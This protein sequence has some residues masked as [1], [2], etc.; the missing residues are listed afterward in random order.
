MPSFPAAA[1]ARVNSVETLKPRPVLEW[2]ARNG[3]GVA[4]FLMSAAAIVVESATVKL[5]RIEYVASFQ[6][7]VVTFAM[8]GMGLGSGAL[9]ARKNAR[10]SREP[11][12]AAS[13]A[14]VA[15][16]AFVLGQLARPSGTIL[17]FV[18]LNVL[19][20]GVFVA[21]GAALT[22]LFLHAE[23][24]RVAYAENLGGSGAGAA[25]LPVLLAHAGLE[26]ALVVVALALALVAS[27]LALP[28]RRVLAAT[29]GAVA[30]AVAIAFPTLAE[31]R[32]LREHTRASQRSSFEVTRY[33]GFSRIDVRRD[34]APIEWALGT[35]YSGPPTLGRLFTIDGV[36]AGLARYSSY[37]TGD[38][39]GSLAWDITALP[40]HA[41]A[42]SPRVLVIG[43]GGGKDVVEAVRNARA[44]SVVAVEINP[45]VID[46]MRERFPDAYRRAYDDPRVE[47]RIEDVR[48]FLHRDQR[49]FDLIE[50]STLQ[51][52]ALLSGPAAQLEQSYV[53]TTEAIDAYLEHLTDR[54]V[55]SV[56]WYRAKM[57]F[58]ARI[59]ATVSALGPGAADRMFLF[60]GKG[61]AVLVVA[62][63]RLTPERHAVLLAAANTLGFSL[64]APLGGNDTL[65]EGGP[66]GSR[67]SLDVSPVTDDRPFFN[68]FHAGWRTSLFGLDVLLMVAAAVCAV[69]GVKRRRWVLESRG[70]APATF[71]V[72][73]GVG[74]V[75]VELYLMQKL[76]L[77]IAEPLAAF[78]VVLTTLL[79]ANGLGSLMASRW[80][81]TGSRALVVLM[82][83]I[84]VYA[85]ALR[86][87]VA[88]VVGDA[89][90][91]R[92]MA[93]AISIV[94]LGL[95]MGI[96][97]AWGLERIAPALT[98][99]PFA[100]V[101]NAF[102]TVVGMCASEILAVQLG[103]SALAG[104]GIL[105][106]GV[107]WASSRSSS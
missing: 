93:A 18:E 15:A 48:S 77:L 12:R 40:E 52:Q 65:L 80:S 35:H 29:C 25:L 81:L 8:F 107:A 2:L 3:A 14:S 19:A 69:L 64:E 9:L 92:A 99:V 63:Q 31:P 24:L 49:R 32:P 83:L 94:P 53:Y 72:G 55:F 68:A 95:C 42:A 45:L 61:M 74:Y 56:A 106:Y 79:V 57:P 70:L 37:V 46:V 102:A 60:S 90:P 30:V 82:A 39:T 13:I 28:K 91:F 41:L 34:D 66:G 21:L 16:A 104:L 38:E 4:L 17:G 71:F 44:A 78:T 103:Y 76:S 47:L 89:L 87:F 86:P 22:S 36:G 98:A 100:F 7:L 51:V 11:A 96:P 43:S 97:F 6:Y 33:N 85:V 59:A 54:G 101:V 67:R 105:G 62:K 20:L 88:S 73:L 26:G 10:V 50:I 84:A 5:F 75:A 58:F 27:A 1:V 23:N